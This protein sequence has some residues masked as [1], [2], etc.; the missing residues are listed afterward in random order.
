M[1]FTLTYRGPLRVNG[2]P[3]HKQEIRRAIHRQMKLL[4]GQLPLSYIAKYLVDGPPDPGSIALIHRVGEFR[5]APLVSPQL[6]LIAE[7]TIT[8]L[9]PEE[10]GSL[11]TQGGDIDNRLKTLLDALRM[12]KVISELPRNEA[13][14]EGEDPFYCLLEDDNLVTKLAVNTDRLLEPANNASEVILVIHVQIKGTR[15]I[16]ANIGLT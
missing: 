7:L 4:W 16:W 15:G 8:F 2:S 6:A 5:L 9:R 14:K 12:P 10:P 13:P 3:T 11:I 1:E